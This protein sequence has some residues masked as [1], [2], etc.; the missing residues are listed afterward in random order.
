MRFFQLV[1]AT[2]VLAMLVVVPALG[3]DRSAWSEVVRHAG[4]RSSV[5]LGTSERAAAPGVGITGGCK[6]V[7]TFTSSAVPEL[8]KDGCIGCHG[9]GSATATGALDL[10][11]VDKDNAAACTQALKAVN[12]TSKPQSAI[13]QA[14]A[15]AQAHV[16]GKVANAPAF[17]SALLGWINNE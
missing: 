4:T 10:T 8:R 7:A 17:T 2:L 11:N 9:G 5:A 3:D 1:P 6:S 16:G 15:G 12:P 13:I 14:A